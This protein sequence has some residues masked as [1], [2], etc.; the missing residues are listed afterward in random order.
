MIQIIY[1]CIPVSC[2]NV[3]QDFDSLLLLKD[4]R[5]TNI[6]WSLLNITFVAVQQVT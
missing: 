1:K 3:S 2:I 5:G 4:N 6:R